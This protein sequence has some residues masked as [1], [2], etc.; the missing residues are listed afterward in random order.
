[1]TML[2]D[3]NVLLRLAVKA[4]PQH[5]LAAEAILKLDQ[6][7]I[8][9]CLVPQVLYEYWVV[10]T[11]PLDVNGLGLSIDEARDSIRDLIAD[12]RNSS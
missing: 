8:E 6:A 12:V 4:D 9:L 2:I 1:M 10:A 5:R 7:D 11:R 3:A